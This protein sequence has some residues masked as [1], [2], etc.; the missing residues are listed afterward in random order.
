[1]TNFV[2]NVAKGRVA[3]YGTLPGIGDVLA[4]VPL[5]TAGME[6]DETMVKRTTLADVLTASQEQTTLGRKTLTNVSTQ[7]DEIT[8]NVSVVANE[9]IYAN[10]SGSPIAALLVCYIPDTSDPDDSVAI[11]LLKYDFSAIP[12]GNDIPVQ[13]STAGLYVVTYPEGQNF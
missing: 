7:I 6:A 4:V 13:F 10:A 1:M 9:F 3:H 5:Q 11:P 8:N 2:F 12:N